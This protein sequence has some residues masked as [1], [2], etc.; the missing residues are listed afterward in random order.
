MPPRVTVLMPVFNREAFVGEAIESVLAQDFTDFEFV[1]VD[2]ASTDRTPELLR[3]WAARDL[4]IVV[5]TA[6]RNL[7]IAEAP[8][9]GLRHARAEYVAR[10]DSDDV[11][12]PGRMAA[13]AAALDQH[14]DVVLV[15][16]AYELMDRDGHYR[17]TWHVDEPH[18]VVTYLLNF[19]NIVGGGG[20]VMFRRSEV[21]A[22]GGYDAAYP[23]S[24][25]Y[26][27]WTRL[28]RRGRVLTLPII[29]MKQRDHE[30]RATIEYRNI[31]RANWTA[32][33]K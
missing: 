9:L 8:N 24:E 19:F 22:I 27:L 2:D 5:I 18:E 23:S 3:A 10:L 1:I 15:S 32:I 28:L 11:M 16:C 12:T 17:G 33:M 6:P 13:Q 26:D 7:G 25:D 21:L 30:G 31:K 4:R 29:G 20:H 14:H